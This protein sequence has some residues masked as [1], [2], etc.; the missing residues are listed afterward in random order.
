M[1]EVRD[2]GRSVVVSRRALLEAERA[3][4]GRE[5]LANLAVGSVVEGTVAS[6]QDYGAF[7][8][9][10]GVRGLIHISE[11]AHGRVERVADVVTPGETVKVKV[12]GIE[13]D[14][15][16]GVQPKIR[17]SMRA[18][19]QGGGGRADREQKVVQARV[20]KVEAFGLVIEVE[21]G[22]GVVPHRELALPHGG[23]PRRVYPPGKEVRVVSMGA[24]ASGRARYSIKGVEDA[25]ARA[26]YREFSKGRPKKSEMGSLGDLL[27]AKLGSD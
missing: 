2:N 24:D 22:Q 4:Q 3:E 8:D 11:L 12:V 13:G 6:L 14:G 1:L 23:D 18:L 25:E 27:K 16:D 20:R 19:T 5:L 21:D 15:K 9:L 7:V 17:L 26:A 10:G